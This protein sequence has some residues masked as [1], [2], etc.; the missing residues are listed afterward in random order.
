MSTNQPTLLLLGCG[1]LGS[2]LGQHYLK[3]GWRVIGARRRI[4]ALP[5]N[6]ETLA[7]DFTEA[8]S[9]SA[10]GGIEADYVVVTLTPGERSEAAYRSVFETGLAALLAALNTR[11][12][13]RLLF[14][15][16]TSVYHQN[17]GAWVNEQ[18]PVEPSTYSGRA[19]LAGEQLLRDSGLPVSLI[20]FGGIYGGSSLRLAERVHAG[21]CAPPEPV[22]YSNRIHRDDCVRVLQHLIDRC[23]AGDTL[24]DCYLA[25]DNAPAPIAEVHQWLAA[26][27]DVSYRCDSGYRHMAGSKRGNNQRLR[28][29]GFVFRYPDYRSGYTAVLKTTE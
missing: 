12:L 20:R 29:S 15:S 1:Q 18:S 27:L 13:K 23:E 11:A 14:T 2:A 16:S 5:A 4:E 26:Q 7:M 24:A 17:D 3:R 8:A 28:D 25:V 9:L 19:V 6:V 10:L 21:H 22:H